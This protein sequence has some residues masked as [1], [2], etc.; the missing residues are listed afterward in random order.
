MDDRS[1][2]NENELDISWYPT[3]VEELHELLT[4]YRKQT[5]VF[6]KERTEYEN[7]LKSLEMTNE[8]KHKL[9]WSLHEKN[10]LN[11]DLQK[12]LSDTHILLYKEKNLNIKLSSDVKTLNA[13]INELKQNKS[14]L[15]SLLESANNNINKI[16]E[17][18]HKNKRC[19]ACHDKHQNIQIKR[20]ICNQSQNPSKLTTIYLPNDN[21][22]TIECKLNAKIKELEEFKHQTAKINEYLMNDRNK[23]YQ[24]LDKLRKEYNDKFEKLQNEISQLSQQHLYNLK[25]YLNYRRNT[26]QEIHDLKMNVFSTN[27]EK[28]RI[29]EKYND[30]VEEIKVNTK[31]IKKNIKK[32]SN[33][34]INGL[35]METMR[36]H[37]ELNNVKDEL[38]TLT[39]SYQFDVKN[40]KSKLNATKRKNK[41]LNQINKCQKIGIKTDIDQLKQRLGKLQKS[42]N[43]FTF[44]NSNHNKYQISLQNEINKIKNNLL[45]LAKSTEL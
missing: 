32:E 7:I 4:F 6:K 39:K 42:I 13:E 43:N 8:E 36:K 19:K 3:S 25:E 16:V 27:S 10:E 5:V 14:H 21:Q 28:N 33:K 31:K 17:N 9:E 11:R 34:L 15:L 26:K 40:L 29:K 30:R 35:R 20:I 12:Q 18:H 22:E 41:K 2:A 23:T 1:E 24:D 44:E 45:E 37:E 38:K